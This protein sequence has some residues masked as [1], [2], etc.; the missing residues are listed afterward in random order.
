MSR[1]CALKAYREKFPGVILSKRGLKDWISVGPLGQG[2]AN[3]K[4][5][6]GEIS[7]VWLKCR[8]EGGE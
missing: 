4:P 6:G 3:V 8:I 7:Q 1:V 2:T 5:E